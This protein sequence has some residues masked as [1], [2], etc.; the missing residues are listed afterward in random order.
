MV[1]QMIETPGGLEMSG[2]KKK[3]SLRTAVAGLTG[4]ACVFALSACVRGTTYGTGV[5]QEAQTFDDLYNM[6]TLKQQRKDID[7]SE[8][9]DLVVPQDKT[10]LPAPVETEASTSNP[11]WPESPEERIARV[12]E[13][14]GEADPRSGDYSVQEQLRKKEGIEVETYNPKGEFVAG[15]TDR[16]GNP[17]LYNSSSKEARK[18]VLE[19][20][21]SQS[22]STGASRKYLTEPPVKYRVPADTAP[23]GEEALTEE[24]LLKRK[25][26]EEER[27][28]SYEEAKPFSSKD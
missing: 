5:T 6:F 18:K 4:L 16:D 23:S 21:T 9:P 28:K 17:L 20:K 15:K 13:Q 19:A 3:M 1:A 11:A 25:L 12:R 10:A 14:A 24:E 7:Y 2:T 26:A 8:R 27:T 22:I